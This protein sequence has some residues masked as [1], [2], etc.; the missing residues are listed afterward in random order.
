M[1]WTPQKRRDSKRF[2][3]QKVFKTE[4]DSYKIIAKCG[5][6]ISFLVSGGCLIGNQIDQVN[7][8][9]E[10]FYMVLITLQFGPIW[11]QKIRINL[12]LQPFCRRR[13]QFCKYPAM[14][15]MN[16]RCVAAEGVDGREGGLQIRGWDGMKG[17]GAI[18]TRWALILAKCKNYPT[19][20]LPLLLSVSNLSF[21]VACC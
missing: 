1:W 15:G 14:R 20:K 16:N 12:F 21:S 3:S 18:R 7:G 6:S 10:K 11:C 8:A 4:G 13:F 17:D 9:S 19:I 2:T 5:F